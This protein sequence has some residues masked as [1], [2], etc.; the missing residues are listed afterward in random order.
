MNKKNKTIIKTN[1]T[2]IFKNLLIKISKIKYL[3]T[4]SKICKKNIKVLTT[5]R[6]FNHLFQI[7]NS[8]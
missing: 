1:S 7:K 4:H 6:K 2:K 3:H 8:N 5:Q